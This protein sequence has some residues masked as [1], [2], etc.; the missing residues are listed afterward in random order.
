MAG[1][2]VSGVALPSGTWSK[3]VTRA[4]GGALSVLLTTTATVGNHFATGPT[5]RGQTPWSENQNRVKFAA[6]QKH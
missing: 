5:T 3:S 4:T 6:W 2:V 1:V